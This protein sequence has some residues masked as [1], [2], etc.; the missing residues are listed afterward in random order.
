L[1]KRCTGVFPDKTAHFRAPPD[2]GAD[3][4][5]MTITVLAL[6]LAM[7]QSAGATVKGRVVE[8][9]TGGPLKQVFVAIESTGL[10]AR[11]N[12]DGVFVL[13]NVAPG[14]HVLF[15][16]VVGYALVRREIDV[17]TAGL[18]VTVALSEGTGAYA[19]AV[20]VSADR[21]SPEPAV[22]AQQFLGSADLQNLRGVLADD[23][24]RAVQV[25]PGVAAG[26][27]LR[28]EFTV[29]GSG[30][31]HVNMIVDGFH[32]PHILHTVRAVEDSTATSCRMSCSSPAVTHSATATA[33]D[34]R[35]SSGCVKGRAPAAMPA[36]R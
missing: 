14:R 12:E 33:S 11:T 23:P 30:F 22:A 21:F 28:S 36:S 20:T 16:S 9:V 34:R 6:L 15:V 10:A 4:T 1:S 35:S 29:R 31:A 13:T 2:S 8:S 17:T 19:E 26:D 25:L 27:D 5:V 7:T 32:A 24:L 18:E 3:E